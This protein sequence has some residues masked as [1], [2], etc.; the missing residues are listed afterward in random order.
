MFLKGAKLLSFR[1]LILLQNAL[2]WCFGF[3]R[4]KKQCGNWLPGTQSYKNA[5]RWLGVRYCFCF[6]LCTQDWEL[7]HWSVRFTWVSF[8]TGS[9]NPVLSPSV[10]VMPL[11]ESR[12]LP[13][14]PDLLP[15]KEKWP[16]VQTGGKWEEP[17]HSSDHPCRKPSWGQK[18]RKK[19]KKRKLT[20]KVTLLL[21]SWA[22]W[23]C[24]LTY[25]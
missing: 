7:P 3:S 18:K 4:S 8:L 5:G 13:T 21:G 11:S 19:R 16:R 24:F 23:S 1:L 17:S 12:D 9:I 6:F 10:G 25:R 22:E 15:L 2:F 14:Y 20:Y